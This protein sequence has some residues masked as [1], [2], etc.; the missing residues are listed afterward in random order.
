MATTNI[1]PFGQ[2]NGVL[3]TTTAPVAND[4]VTDEASYALSAAQGVRLKGLIDDI[5]SGGE[6]GGQSGGTTTVQNAD[7]A[8]WL[9]AC[10]MRLFNIART[11]WSP[12]ASMPRSATV[13]NTTPLSF[14]AGTVYVG[15]PYSDTRE[16]NKFI[17]HQVSFYT[18]LTAV[19][20]RYSLLYTECLHRNAPQSKYG[21]TYIATDQSA[22]YYGVH[23]SAA[24]DYIIGTPLNYSSRQH[25]KNSVLANSNSTA[26][27]LSYVCTSPTADKVQMFDII[28][29]F[30]HCQ[31]VSDIQRNSDGTVANIEI[32]ESKSAFQS[33]TT[34]CVY[35]V[36]YTAS[37][38]NSEFNQ[39]KYQLYRPDYTK[40]RTDFEDLSNIKYNDD[41]CTIAGDRASFRKGDTIGINYTI[42]NGSGYDRMLIRR[43]LAVIK[44]VT[45]LVSNDESTQFEDHFV[46]LT[47]DTLEEGVYNAVLS[48]SD[49]SVMSEPT[50]FEVIDTYVTHTFDSSSKDITVSFNSDRGTPINVDLVGYRTSGTS[51][52]NVVRRYLE[53]ADRKNGKTT[54]S[55]SDEWSRQINDYDDGDIGTSN[56]LKLRVLF[57]GEFGVVCSE[58]YDTTVTVIK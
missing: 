20:N 3:P 37:S 53:D 38:F 16:V 33:T 19:H 43:D 39:S 42:K 4:L 45:G 31:I 28:W 10:K 32:T 2:G 9:K 49:G 27:W 5:P 34:R 36:T 29:R 47:S 46:D 26:N 54:F 25:T 8:A 35:R 52:H 56:P 11:R 13:Y 48:N 23:C 15:M 30:G 55:V 51:Y 7:Y 1:N 18:F 22:T 41:I 57:R 58:L 44:T 50:T 21:K 6:S 12:V 17:G 40:L 24:V 14:S